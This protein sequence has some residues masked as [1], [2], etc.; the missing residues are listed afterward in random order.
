MLGLGM[1]LG[2][3]ARILGIVGGAGAVAWAMRDRFVT[4]ALKREP[5]H[6]TFTLPPEQADIHTVEPDDLTAIPG[7]GPVFARRLMEA[8]V[9]TY[10][11]L[12]TADPARVAEIVNVTEG[13]AGKWIEA[14]ASL[15]TP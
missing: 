10:R 6:P 15:V 4:L 7:I 8:G 12:A 1:K 11:E 2:K 14:A 9:A 5:D 13:R 3:L